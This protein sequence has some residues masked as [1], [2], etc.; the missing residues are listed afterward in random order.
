ME[1]IH[2]KAF[3]RSEPWGVGGNTP[4]NAGFP[5]QPAKGEAELYVVFVPLYGPIGEGI[6]CVVILICLDVP[7]IYS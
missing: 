4:R 2:T 7:I 3:E 1:S 6:I 5:F